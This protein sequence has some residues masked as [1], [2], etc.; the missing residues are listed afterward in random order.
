MV[1]AQGKKSEQKIK[2]VIDDGSGAKTLIDTTYKDG[3]LP[4]K[5]ELENGNV[6]VIRDK[7]I[8]LSDI[9]TEEGDQK[10]LVTV[11]SD[12]GDKKAISNKVIVTND[13]NS[14]G[15]TTL[16]STED[17]HVY[18]IS[19]TG[20]AP[21]KHMIIASSGNSVSLMDGTGDEQV[22]VIKDE[23]SE[24]DVKSYS[25]KVTSSEDSQT[26][27]SKY[28]IAKDGMVITVEGNDETRAKEI[29]DMISNKLDI[30]DGVNGDK[31]QVKKETEK[32]VK[33]K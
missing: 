21:D 2:V 29:I 7:D 24:G 4:E 22:F 9:K 28:I 14:D 18:V 32:T 10:I 3:N 26:D 5:I 15:E 16:T 8:D 12:S 6:I 30:K 23:K 31:N 1:S 17:K 33:K 13:L 27:V 20:D 11:S 25:I 19:K